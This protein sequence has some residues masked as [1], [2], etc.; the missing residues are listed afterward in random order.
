MLSV[1]TSDKAVKVIQKHVNT[2][3]P[4]ICEDIAAKL[5]TTII[6]VLKLPKMQDIK[7]KNH[8]RIGIVFH[9]SL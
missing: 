9:I 6:K 8:K 4:I 1:L 2:G 3:S 7:P 5:E